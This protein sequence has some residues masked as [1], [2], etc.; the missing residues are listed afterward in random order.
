VTT[1][2]NGTSSA[3]VGATRAG[4]RA[5]MRAMIVQL[6]RAGCTPKEALNLYAVSVGL[7]PI[8]AGWRAAEIERLRF[9]RHLVATGRL[10]S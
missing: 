2:T 5:S 1:G 9:L 7:R 10:L 4:D 8:A 3:P 6:L